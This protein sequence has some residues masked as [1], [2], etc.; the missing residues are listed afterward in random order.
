M[1]VRVQRV[2]PLRV[3]DS[4]I[5]F[6]WRMRAWPFATLEEYARCWDWRYTAIPEGEPIAWIALDGERIVG[7]VACNVRNFVLNGRAVCAAIPGNFLV[8]PAYRNTIIGAQLAGTPMKLT[9]KGETDIF[10]GYGNQ[11]AH[12]LALGLGC[13]ELG[14][15]R[16]FID[17][18]RP[19]PA[20]G[21]RIPGGALLAPVATGA[22]ATLRALTGRRRAS[23]PPGLSVRRLAAPELGAIDRSSWSVPPGLS[24]RGTSAYLAKRF[25]EC[26]IRE[27]RADAIVD[28]ASGAAEAIVI[29]E[30]RGRFNV[31]FVLA[32]VARVSEVQA[33]ELVATANPEIEL[34]LVP[35]LPGTRLARDFA[36]SAYLE[37]SRANSDT[38][39]QNTTWSALWKPTHPA[40]EEFAAVDAWNVWY[41]WNSH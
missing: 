18:R 22:L 12:K 15:M 27:Y 35:L 11:I 37:R 8:D 10:I 16:P 26:P 14:P 9:Q 31:I 1:G 29:S 41:G 25:L 32:N 2:N 39:L 40:A 38:V 21:R 7:H 34:V 3:R 6:F 4:A 36:H 5:D 13:R 28:A 17:V 24:W 30:G 23:P 20:L 33:I 19:G